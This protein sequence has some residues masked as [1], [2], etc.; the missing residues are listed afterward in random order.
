MLATHSHTKE[1]RYLNWAVDIA[2]DWARQHPM[3]EPQ[4]SMAW[5]DMAIG[6]RAYKLGYLVEAAARSDQVD[7]TAFSLL[8]SCA[9]L[10]LEALA[11][12]QFFAAHSNHGFYVAAGQMALARRLRSLPGMEPHRGQ[13]RERVHELVR[14][15]F[16]PTG[17]H[18]EHSPDYHRMVLDTF[19]GLIESELLDRTEFA[20]LID[21]IQE[22][23]SWFVLPNNRLAMFGDTNHRDVLQEHRT[24]ALNPALEFV[25]TRGSQGKPPGD[26]WRS[27]DDAGFFVAR[28][29]WPTG[30]EDYADCS[31]LAQ[32]AG[33]HSRVHKHA[34]DLSMVWY[35]RG[36]E[37]LVDAGKFGYL[38][39]TT[40]ES[41]L[42]RAG[43]YYAHPSRVYVEST[44]AHNTVEID[45]RSYQRRGVKPYGSGLLR[46]GEHQGVFY[47]GAHVRHDRTIR[48]AR[49]L[50]FR[51]GEWLLVYDWLWDNLD[52]PHTYTQRFHLA[53]ELDMTS[54]GSGFEVPLP[55][56]RLHMVPLLSARALPAVR[57]RKEPEPLGWI[58][59]QDGEFQPC[60]TA[61][62]Q[63]SG[64]ASCSIATLLGFG[65]R[66][67]VPGESTASVRGDEVRLRWSRAGEEWE[68]GFGRPDRED[69]QFRV[70]HTSANGTALRRAL[71][72]LRGPRLS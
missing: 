40:P 38:D 17:V 68:V 45:G 43:F 69:F 23:L 42:G 63:I 41:E 49:V 26:R 72:W 65:E 60:W 56:T 18:R 32:T 46:S 52:Q 54:A 2:L 30:P 66:A 53:P 34:D 37:I 16:T 67:P 27:F 51:P 62:Y 9:K 20:P 5:Y 8:L 70:R 25:L 4:R 39:R 47:S 3:V 1:A 55:D 29:R 58:S 61:A 7:D 28:D 21:R 31:Y 48:H 71:N 64:G 22:A 35:D 44:R 50:A 33:F 14:R 24:R 10:H 11:D 36:R 19:Q 57:G 6:L 15:Q 12:P 13:A 59:R